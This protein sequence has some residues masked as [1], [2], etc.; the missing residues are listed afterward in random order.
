MV[1]T[2]KPIADFHRQAT[3]HAG[4]TQIEGQVLDLSF[5]LDFYFAFFKLPSMGLIVRMSLFPARSNLFS[6]RYILAIDN[7]FIPCKT[8]ISWLVLFTIFTIDAF[9]YSF[10]TPISI[11][12]TQIQ[13][14]QFLQ[15]RRHQYPFSSIHQ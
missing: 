9:H 8:V 3:A 4:R 12:S 10:M 11:R 6:L 2:A 1:P 15:Y 5:P 13:Y 7:N 14:H